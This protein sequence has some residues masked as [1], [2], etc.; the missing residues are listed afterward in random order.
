MLD[1]S[2]SLCSGKNLKA[3]EKPYDREE[4]CFWNILILV[5]AVWNGNVRGCPENSP[6]N[7]SKEK[8][9]VRRPA[10][11]KYSK[12]HREGTPVCP[13]IISLQVLLSRGEN[14]LY[15]FCSLLSGIRLRYWR[16]EEP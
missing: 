15:L 11:P 2:L 5:A 6:T 13:T 16:L 14:P 10:G 8:G 1:L 12:D 9:I 7:K 4:A 3:S